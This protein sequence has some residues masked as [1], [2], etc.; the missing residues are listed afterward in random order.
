M[1]GQARRNR[2]LGISNWFEFDYRDA[3]CPDGSVNHALLS[4]RPLGTDETDSDYIAGIAIIVALMHL[5]AVATNSNPT[6]VVFTTVGMVERHA[7]RFVDLCMQAQPA[8]YQRF[9]RS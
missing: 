6:G 5:D 2:E 4:D 1:G 7:L 3:L 9:L 8:I